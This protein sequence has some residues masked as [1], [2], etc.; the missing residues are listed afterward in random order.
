MNFYQAQDQAR[1]QTFWLVFLFIVAIVV[2]VLLTNLCV[3]FFVLYSN[4]EYALNGVDAIGSSLGNPVLWVENLVLALGWTKFLWV[5][6]LVVG[7]IAIA[8]LFKWLEMRQGGRVV[9]ESL[10][11][12]LV[13]TNS[14]NPQERQLLNVVEEIALAAGIPVPQVYLLERE[15][16]I[17]AFAAGLS[18]E[19]AVIG[20]TQGSLDAFN[21]DQLQGVIAHEFS[22][23][24]N[25]DMRLNIKLLVVLHG[26][27]LI[28]ESGRLFLRMASHSGRHSRRD[29]NGGV[30]AGLFAFGLSLWILGAIGQLFAKIIKSAV[31]RQR[32]FLADASAVQFTRNPQGIGEAL[33]IIGGASY[34]S[35]VNNHRAHEMSHL[36][37]SNSGTWSSFFGKFFATHPPLDE[38]IKRVWPNWRGKYI[39]IAQPSHSVDERASGFSSTATTVKSERKIESVLAKAVVPKEG[40]EPLEFE[41]SECQQDNISDL[42][43]LIHEPSDA[44]ALIALLLRDDKPDIWLKQSSMIKTH[45]ESFAKRVLSLSDKTED[46]LLEQRLRLVELAV[47][48]LKS[49]SKQQYIKL[50]ELYSQLVRAD[51]KVDLSE[52]L[53]FQLLR[54][55]CDRHFGMSRPLKPK[56]KSLKQISS[57]YQIVLSKLV[58]AGDHQGDE[59]KA[60]NR[61][62]NA[63]GLYNLSI[64]SR[65]ECGGEKFSNALAQLSLS[66]PLLKPR[67]VKGLIAAAH[68]NEVVNNKE[69]CLIK[70]IAAVM[71]CPLIGLDL[72]A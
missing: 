34:H 65:D 39:S 51:G 14:E 6:L 68:S 42:E 40:L 58:Y 46:L 55:H 17:N 54:Q 12:R 28:G 32:E 27:L 64:L 60:F 53:F 13:L 19:D 23:I 50:R 33:S 15:H 35:E 3:A 2:L 36:F 29:R 57:F 56:Y 4:P 63:S 7:G 30:I 16:G 62:C 71:D 44:A 48:S 5:T 67:L 61:A 11:G 20:V 47:P 38:R 72:E 41:L 37:F 31:S 52:W 10:G 26:I 69:Y 59:V 24:L 21:R 22:H 8:I 1:K 25:G 43:S 70:G 66:F 18:P 9:A 49:I 45:D